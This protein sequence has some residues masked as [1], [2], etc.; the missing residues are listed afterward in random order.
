M[1][2]EVLIPI[3]NGKGSKEI[4]NG[5]YTVTNYKCK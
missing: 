4:E 3:T 5:N 2:K 1:S